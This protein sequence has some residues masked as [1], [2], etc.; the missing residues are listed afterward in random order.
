MIYLLLILLIGCTP[1]VK[2]CVPLAVHEKSLDKF[3]WWDHGQPHY[4]IQNRDYDGCITNTVNQW[5]I[6]E[7]EFVKP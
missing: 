4:V 1:I 3:A 7:E 2:R 6:S 5:E